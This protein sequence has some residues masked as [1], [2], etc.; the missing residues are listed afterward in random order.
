MGCLHLIYIYLYI[1][2]ACRQGFFGKR[3]DESCPPGRFGASCGG[4][5]F[6]KC[7]DAECDPVTGCQYNKIKPNLTRTLGRQQLV[8]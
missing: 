7:T 3:C 1:Y 4:R 5:C 2:A 8:D 6:P